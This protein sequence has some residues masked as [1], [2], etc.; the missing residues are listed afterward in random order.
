MRKECGQIENRNFKGNQV[1]TWTKRK[2]ELKR[3]MGMN[4]DKKKTRT[5][6]EIRTEHGQ[7][8]NRN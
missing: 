1:G 2:Q 6:K 3:K 4:V 7:K 8:E 5:K